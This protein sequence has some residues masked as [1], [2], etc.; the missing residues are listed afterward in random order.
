MGKTLTNYLSVDEKAAQ[1]VR[2][3]NEWFE[4]WETNPVRALRLIKKAR[5]RFSI[6]D[7]AVGECL[8]GEY[9]DSDSPREAWAITSTVVALNKNDEGRWVA[10]TES[11]SLYLLNNPFKLRNFNEVVKT[12]GDMAPEVFQDFLHRMRTWGPTELIRWENLEFAI[13]RLVKPSSDPSVVAIYA[14]LYDCTEEEI[15]R[16]LEAKEL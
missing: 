5:G 16:R 3:H 8:I 10:K 2:D 14:I 1:F 12:I 15:L 4:K 7:V 6:D 13:K 11:G 9:Y